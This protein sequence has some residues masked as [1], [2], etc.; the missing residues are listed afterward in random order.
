MLFRD[1]TKSCNVCL[2]FKRRLLVVLPAVLLVAALYAIFRP[3]PEPSYQGRSLRTWLADFDKDLARNPRWGLAPF[4]IQDVKRLDQKAVEA[5]RQIGTNALP[6]LLSWIRYEAPAWNTKLKGLLKKAGISWSPGL[7]KER[8]A[9]RAQVAF[10]I[11][12]PRAKAAIPE[13]TR[14]TDDS[15]PSIPA[16]RAILALSCLGEA[17]VPPLVSLITNETRHHELRLRALESMA[18]MGTNA[19][20][21][22][23]ALIQCLK[24]P[25]RGIRSL[26]AS[27]LGQLKSEPEL[28]VPA[29]TTTMRDADADVRYCAITALGQFGSEARSATPALLN[30]LTDPQA[31]VRAQARNTLQKIAPEI[32]TNAAPR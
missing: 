9:A 18:W 29:L 28:V 17:A 27:D 20:A 11:L 3:Q 2:M 30:S 10:E 5:I 32:L 24:D 16:R 21:A 1:K 26:A 31:H 15:R 7:D 14:V 22:V 25:D 6:F 12:G 23:P 4:L 13:L 8:R 19:R